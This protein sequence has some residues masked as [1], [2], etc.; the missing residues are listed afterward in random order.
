MTDN[1]NE[2]PIVVTR[3]GWLISS[4]D[5]VVRRLARGETTGPAFVL[6]VDHEGA[7]EETVQ[8]LHWLAESLQAIEGGESA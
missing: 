3:D 2:P 8:R 1:N 6:Q 7:D 5:G 4:L